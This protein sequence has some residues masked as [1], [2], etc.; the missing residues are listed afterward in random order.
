MS[1]IY[2]K[3]MLC[4]IVVIIH[5]WQNHDVIHLKAL[6]G[7]KG[8]TSAQRLNT[9]CHTKH[10]FNSVF[11]IGFELLSSQSK[12]SVALDYSTL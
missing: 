4:E 5:S 9:G 7:K 6:K 3:Y 8:K 2:L 1:F 10:V 11:Y 12:E